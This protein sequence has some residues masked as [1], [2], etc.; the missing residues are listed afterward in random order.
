MDEFTSAGID[1]YIPQNLVEV[2]EGCNQ[3]DPPGEESSWR[4]REALGQ[5]GEGFNSWS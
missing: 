3:R 5:V 2:L 4:L 1:E